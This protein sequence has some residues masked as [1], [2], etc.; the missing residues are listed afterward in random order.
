VRPPGRRGVARAQQ[1]APA[2]P[3]VANALASVLAPAEYLTPSQWAAKHL[4]VPDGPYAGDF[5]NATLAP[6][7]VEPLDAFA[8]DI[9]VNKIV[10]RKSAQT[11][12][13]LLA[14]A[15]IGH[16]IDREPCRMMVVQPT[17]GALSE[18]NREKLQPA[19]EQSEPLLERV[20]PQ[21]TR[22]ARG[23]TTYSKRYPGGSLTLAIATSTADLRSRTV[24]KVIK[25]EASEYPFDLDGQGSPHAMIT[26]RYES[27]LATEDWKE[28]NISTPVIK[29]DCYID[30]EFEAG[31][32]RYWHVPCPGCATEFIFTF[33]PCFR[34]NRGYPYDAH[35][36][37]SCCGAVIKHFQKNALVRRGRWVA[38][39]EGP[40][41][42]RS[43]H[44]DA[45]S[46]PFVPWDVIAQRFLEAKDDTTKLKSF[47]NLT[48][49]RA[50]EVRGDAPDHERLMTLREPYERRRIPP[51]C[52]LLTASADVQA[53]AIYVEVVAYAPDKQSWVVEALVLDGDTDDPHG[54]AFRKLSQLYDVQWPDYFGHTRPVDA[55]GVDSGFR[56]N[57]VYNWCRTRPATF[58]LKGG[59]GWSRPA[60]ST[61]S[62]VDV[63]IAGRRIKQGASV[64]TVG[65]W[66][67]KAQLY[68]ALRKQ[69]VAEGADEEPAG[70]C[71]FG[72]WIEPNYFQQLTS[73]YLTDEKFKG[74]MRRT[75]KERGANHF[76]DCRIY[77]NALA[78][79]LGLNRMTPR[80]WSSLARLR[81]V[82]E[83]APPPSLVATPLQQKPQPRPAV[84]RRTRS[85]F[86]DGY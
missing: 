31:D 30:A 59:D 1:A 49:G 65:T 52:L 26:A 63:D 39:H 86:M 18:F 45:L 22:S 24:K 67:L 38:T 77:N 68:A 20:R 74:R 60:I 3:I 13:T 10:I 73:E 29:G 46:S 21:T 9:A 58:A 83:G 76:L 55:F 32:Q 81:D 47:D 23:S 19:I 7:L 40:G 34:F 51:A 27:F 54:G 12:F 53:N 66:S 11:G 43:Y 15:A 71:H 5:F 85:S 28:L 6:Y 80:E 35:Y 16:M 61:P 36:V 62:L 70:C 64:W 42:H 56:S 25:D 41:R 37:T 82:P 2:L 4:I 48:L 17:D 57:V 50:H 69:R 8:D 33:G 79:Y 84:A 44:F 75:W 72:E 78:D 14:I